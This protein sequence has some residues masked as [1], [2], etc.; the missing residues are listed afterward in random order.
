MG[1]GVGSNVSGVGRLGIRAHSWD[2]RN[3]PL[4]VLSAKGEKWRLRAMMQGKV[5]SGEV[6]S[7]WLEGCSLTK[8]HKGT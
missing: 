5:D 2:L 7:K 4:I 1:D 8:A 6:E 3:F